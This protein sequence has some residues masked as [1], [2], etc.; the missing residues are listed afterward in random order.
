M[1]HLCKTR[2]SGS[3]MYYGMI[4]PS[5]DIMLAFVSAT[6]QCCAVLANDS[7]FISATLSQ[8]TAGGRKHSTLGFGSLSV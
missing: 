4:H 1:K 8:L 3:S 2:K 6:V 7:L 5:H